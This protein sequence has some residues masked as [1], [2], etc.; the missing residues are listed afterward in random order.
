MLN[1]KSQKRSESPY[2][3]EMR[4]PYL[5]VRNGLES[6][7][8]PIFS[9]GFDTLVQNAH[10]ETSNHGPNQASEAVDPPEIK[11]ND[12]SVASMEVHHH[13]VHMMA[14]HVLHGIT[15]RLGLGIM[16]MMC[17]MSMMG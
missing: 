1:L 3:S 11:Q 12:L 5:I 14:A 15:H 10:E 9:V 16:C 8:H 7:I 17:I 2:K 13:H 6:T 4:K